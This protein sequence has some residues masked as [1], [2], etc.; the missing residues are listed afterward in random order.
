MLVTTEKKKILDRKKLDK[1]KLDKNE[2]NSGILTEE[3]IYIM[4]L[5]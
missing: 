5:M 4:E 2:G 1:K 3:L